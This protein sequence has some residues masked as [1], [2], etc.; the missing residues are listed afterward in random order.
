MAQP[1]SLLS[2]HEP[3]GFAM[4]RGKA[5]Q[6]RGQ[7]LVRRPY[8]CPKG[9]CPQA[10]FAREAIIWDRRMLTGT[11]FLLHLPADGL[12]PAA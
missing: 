10:W 11:M 12:R 5:E 9:G 6:R 4:E 7:D 2:G 8:Y 3:H 1:S